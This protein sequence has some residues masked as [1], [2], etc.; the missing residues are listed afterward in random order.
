MSLNDPA[1]IKTGK[2]AEDIAKAFLQQNGLIWVTSNF[3]SR[4]GE[5]D[6]IMQDDQ[7]LVFV[8]VKFRKTN[9][10]GGAISAISNK[11]QEKIRQ[12]A[13]FYLQ[14]NGF[15]EYNTACRFDAVLLDGN[16]NAPIIKWLKD[17]F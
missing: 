6:L 15:N 1:N 11:K 5:V 9:A 2:R 17:A 12:C 13:T 10:F 14:Q 4:Q 3:H 7:T 8:E 16:I